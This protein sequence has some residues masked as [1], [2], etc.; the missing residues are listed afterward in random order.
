MMLAISSVVKSV[1]F[2]R[3]ACTLGTVS[4]LL[5]LTMDALSLEEDRSAVLGTCICGTILLLFIDCDGV[6]TAWS[7]SGTCTFGT[8]LLLSIECDGEATAYSG[9]S[10]GISITVD[11]S[12][13][14]TL[15][16]I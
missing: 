9:V 13:G 10:T 14:A 11:G 5:S 4:S 16:S 12:T 7:V 8:A 3:G 6:A 2:W 15:V 1:V